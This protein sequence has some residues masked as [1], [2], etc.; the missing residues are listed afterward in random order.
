MKRVGIGIVLLLFNGF[1]QAQLLGG[2]FS[3][4]ATELR[5]NARQIVALQAIGMTSQEDYAALTAG[6]SG[7]GDIHE[8]EYALHQ[9][10]FASLGAVNPSV[11]EMPEVADIVT[12]APEIRGGFSAALG[13][14]SSSGWLASS[15]MAA[16]ADA[17]SALSRLASS[18]LEELQTVLTAGQLIMTDAER[19]TSIRRIDAAVR[20]QYRFMV[21]CCAEG[22]L[23]ADERIQA[24]QD[25]RAMLGAT[26][27]N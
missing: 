21:Q 25:S 12:L 26:G 16:M 15:E 9:R 24:A 11:A 20:E 18:E 27:G 23:L 4:G 17:D 8:A 22:D 3:Q 10:Y 1:A 6:L 14:W 7:I 19:A 5:D 13:R 2:I